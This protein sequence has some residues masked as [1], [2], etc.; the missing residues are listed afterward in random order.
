MNT[1]TRLEKTW[2]VRLPTHAWVVF[3]ACCL[4][5][6]S[7]VLD[8]KGKIDQPVS[9]PPVIN[10]PPSQ[11]VDTGELRRGIKEDF[12]TSSN[13]MANQLTGAVNAPIA[14]LAEK[15][16]GIEATLQT[17]INNTLEVNTQA[18]AELR[19]KLEAM[20]TIMTEIKV[21]FKMITEFNIGIDSKI[22]ADASLIRE[23]SAKV[24]NLN[25]QIAGMANGQVGLSNKLD[26]TIAN[27]S[28]GRDVN[29]LPREA[30]QIMV[31]REKTF[32][33]IIG[34]IMGVI[35]IAIGWIGRNAREREKLRTQAEREERKAT[36]SLL[37]EA[38]TL[39]PDTKAKEVQQIK[40]RLSGQPLKDGV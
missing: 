19:A 14:K 29:Y 36:T 21:T 2:V 25:A 4:L 37:M 1:R 27:L 20:L 15:L 22:S 10:V 24:D 8:Q 33:Y 13:A 23:M 26:S 9:P 6:T 7:C 28:A 35:T 16:T 34:S 12:T 30:V 40:A 5:L 32:M 3:S 18:S 11:T 17:E 38:L 39:M 31:D